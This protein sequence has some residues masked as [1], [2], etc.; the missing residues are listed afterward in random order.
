MQNTKKR[1]FPKKFEDFEKKHAFPK[2][3]P[4]PGLVE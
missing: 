4:I 1:T 3:K 2:L